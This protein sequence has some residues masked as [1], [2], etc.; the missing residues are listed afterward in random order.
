MVIVTTCGPATTIEILFTLIGVVVRYEICEY[1]NSYLRYFYCFYSS[2]SSVNYL[3]I[4]NLWPF[5]SVNSAMWKIYGI[6]IAPAGIS[7]RRRNP[8]DAL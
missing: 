7:P 8:E 1:V 6:F 4:V 3:L 2:T 5:N